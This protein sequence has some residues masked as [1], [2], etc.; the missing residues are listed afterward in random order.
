MPA[1]STLGNI[2]AANEDV[3]LKDAS[4]TERPLQPEDHRD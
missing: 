2:W 3:V 1:R 4:K